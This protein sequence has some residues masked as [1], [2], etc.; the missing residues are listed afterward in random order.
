[1]IVAMRFCTLLAVFCATLVQAQEL[2]TDFPNASLASWTASEGNIH[3]VGEHT[4]TAEPDSYRW[5]HFRAEGMLD[6]QPEFTIGSPDSGFL[7]DLREHRF[8]WSYDQQN[9]DFFDNHSGSSFDF[10]FSND[11]PF[12]QNE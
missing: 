4:W 7:G 2:F 8:V 10:R 12:V 9:W 11:Q 3:L 5:V 1:M 6:L